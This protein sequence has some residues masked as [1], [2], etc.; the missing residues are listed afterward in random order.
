MGVGGGPQDANDYDEDDRDDELAYSRYQASP[1]YEGYAGAAGAEEESLMGLLSLQPQQLGEEAGA[2]R[3]SNDSTNAVEDGGQAG[4]GRR[5]SADGTGLG[6]GNCAQCEGCGAANTTG[7]FSCEAC[8]QWL[9][10]SV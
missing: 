3:Q 9:G 5:Y 2:D 10:G 1:A 7:A 8:G 4:A 6:E